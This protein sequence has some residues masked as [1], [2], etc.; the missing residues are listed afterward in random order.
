MPIGSVLPCPNF[1]GIV[2]VSETAWQYVPKKGMEDISIFKM[3]DGVNDT[4][5]RKSK[6]ALEKSALVVV[7]PE[8]PSAG[9]VSI[10][11]RGSNLYCK[12]FDEQCAKLAMQFFARSFEDNPDNPR[13][14]P[15]CA[16]EV[17]C[18]L[19]SASSTRDLCQFECLCPS[20]G[21]NEIVLVMHAEAVHGGRAAEVCEISFS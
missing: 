12:M 21:C 9:E 3:A 7:L 1:S 2:V 4:C 6:T 10:M 15:L 16:G 11:M 17:T 19:V 5:Y 14:T 18:G 8:T 20:G 13:C